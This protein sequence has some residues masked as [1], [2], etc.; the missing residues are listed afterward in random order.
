MWQVA[1]E[2]FLQS[3]NPSWI[4]Y[5]C[6]SVSTQI[7]WSKNFQICF[8]MTDEDA[9]LPKHVGSLTNIQIFNSILCWYFSQYC[10]GILALWGTRWRSWLRHCA[11]SRKVAGLISDGKR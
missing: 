8:Y 5:L 10:L 4:L 3:L 6:F 2:T 11:T 9:G 1:V 7:W